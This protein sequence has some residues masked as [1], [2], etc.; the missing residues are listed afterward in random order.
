MNRHF[1]DTR[2]YLKRAGG[3]AK[4]GTKKELRPLERR[5]R[6]L[7]GRERKTEPEPEPEAGR[8][9]GLRSRGDRRVGGTVATVRE[10]LR[11]ARADEREESVERTDR[12][13]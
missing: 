5:L 12:E 11:G 9:D 8:F 6:S 10:R 13:R 7:T 4:R 3:A 2:Y 1:E